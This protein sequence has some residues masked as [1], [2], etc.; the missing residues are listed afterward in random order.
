M[1]GIPIVAEPPQPYRTALP[2][3]RAG[4][5]L[6][7]QYLARRGFRI[8]ERGYRTRAGEIDLIAEESGVLVFV[9][10]KSR[11]TLACGRPSEAVG[12]H[13]QRRLM[14]AASQYLLHHRACDR[15]C[16]FDVVEVLCDPSGGGSR[17]HHIRDAFQVE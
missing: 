13:K 4:E 11:T 17:V 1:T 7:A 16:R 2:L 12:P 8:L 9:E 5:I 15:P 3:G 6:A 14:R 10:V